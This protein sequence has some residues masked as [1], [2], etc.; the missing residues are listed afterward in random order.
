MAFN[1]GQTSSGFINIAAVTGK[2]D[3]AATEMKNHYGRNK[4]SL[5]INGMKTIVS[6][7]EFIKKHKVNNYI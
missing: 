1:L 6:W 7:E 4:K 5:N 3:R 2:W